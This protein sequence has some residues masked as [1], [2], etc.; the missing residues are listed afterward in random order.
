MLVGV[1][2]GE[3]LWSP[4][5]KGGKWSKLVHH[6]KDL[7]FLVRSHSHTSQSTPMNLDISPFLG[8]THRE[9]YHFQSG[10]GSILHMHISFPIGPCPTLVQRRAYYTCIFIFL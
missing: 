7:F 4:K 3:C 5:T 8:G 10:R 1:V 9:H 2:S 6:Q